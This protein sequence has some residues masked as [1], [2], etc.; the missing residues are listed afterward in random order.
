MNARWKLI[1]AVALLVLSGGGVAT[2]KTLKLGVPFWK[3]EQVHDWQIEAR[4]SFLATGRS[5]K[6]RLSLPAA[7]VEQMSGQES[8]S[9]G[10]HYNIERN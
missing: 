1:V 6:A 10:Y 5:V 9:L 2:Y 8:G 4:V 3:G 7:A